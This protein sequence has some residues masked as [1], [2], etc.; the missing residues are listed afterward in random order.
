LA[1]VIAITQERRT[2]LTSGWRMLLSAP[3]AFCEPS[4]LSDND[5]WIVAEVPGTAASSLMR[6]GRWHFDSPEPLEGYDFW[7][8]TQIQSGG[9]TNILFEGLATFAEVYIDGIR[10]LTSDNMFLEH[11]H[12]ICQPGAHHLHL[13]F[14]ALT[15][16][17]EEKRKRARWRPRL[18]SAQN[19]RFVR[20]TF[21]GHM[22]SWCPPV[23]AIGPW[24]D[25]F[26]V[27]RGPVRVRKV[28]LHAR[29]DGTRGI[30]DISLELDGQNDAV[31][32]VNCAG[33]KVALTPEANGQIAARLECDSIEP[34][35]PH[36][37]GSPRLYPVTV[38]AGDTSIDLGH[39]GFRRIAVDRDRDGQGFGLT[40]N[41]VPVFCRGANWIQADIIGL[42][43]TRATYLPGL[44]LMRDA[45]MN[46][47]RVPANAT[48]EGDAFYRLCDEL[49]L[50]VWQDFMFAN[51]DYPA[52]DDAFLASVETEARQFLG[53]TQVSPSITVLCG[54]SEIAQQAA[55]FGLPRETWSNAIFDSLLPKLTAEIRPDAI[56]VPHTPY[57]GELPF[58]PHEGISHY[59]GVTAYF[60]PLEDARRANVR[61][62]SECLCF[63]NV[64]DLAP[65][66]LESD[67]PKIEHPIFA[68]RVPNDKGAAWYFED[69]RNFYLEALYGVDAA[70]LRRD[71]PEHFLDLSRAVTAEV[72]ETTFAEW[73]R[74][75]SATRG[76]L[77]WFYQDLWPGSGWGVVDSLGEPKSSYFG[78]KRAFKTLSVILTDE[79]INGLHLHIIN[80][81]PVEKSVRL[82][83]NCLRDGE[84]AVMHATRD[85]TLA[86]RSTI[87]VTA[88]ELWGGFFDTTYAYRFGEPSHDATVAQLYDMESN[89]LAAEAFHFPLGRGHQ[90]HE[91]GLQADLAHTNTGWCLQLEAKK[92]AQSVHILDDVYRPEDNWFH[93]AP[94]HRRQ[95]SL[96]PRFP[97]KAVPKGNIA[98]VNGGRI[99]YGPEL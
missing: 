51:F 56:Y 68:P 41:G 57:G 1:K 31:A 39:V 38:C 6:A 92:L 43:S 64:P 20:T 79:G 94:G 21:L 88:T 48:Y 2:P 61:F 27:T 98:A 91:L 36:T 54:G 63:A 28:E 40:I 60:Q 50:M 16:A 90:R 10:V 89:I 26:Q 52:N 72:M 23:H 7:Y 99:A 85:M 22:P 12:A 78:L 55:M 33:Q 3:A 32:T 45:G 4:V 19:L 93:L 35:W 42:S 34:W 29:L 30:L 76:G 24:R 70:S 37:H 17:L 66:I 71:D 84:T 5:D 95:I 65:F 18:P 11:E 14:R 53:R 8:H 9:F 44:L 86:P 67:A 96:I 73:R 25:I 15:P 13:C 75:N 58:V 59:Y 97:T 74:T 87:M 80:E 49:G 83:L 69:V 62:A 81:T 47:V 82:S 77:V 46:M